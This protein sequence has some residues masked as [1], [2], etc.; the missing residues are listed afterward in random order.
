M[1][2]SIRLVLRS[3]VFVVACVALLAPLTSSAEVRSGHDVTI[4]EQEVISE[5]LYVFARSFTLHGRVNGD[6]TVFASEVRIPG[7]ITGDLLAAAGQV[8]IPG[9]VEGSARVAAGETEITGRVGGDVAA[10][11]GQ[12][13]FGASSRVDRDVLAATSAAEL[14]GSVQG[15]VVG[16]MGALTIA[17][18]VGGN[19][20]VKT[21]KLQLLDGAKIAGTLTYRSEVPAEVAPNASVQGG[22]NHLPVEAEAV[23]RGPVVA[24]LVGWLRALIGLFGLGVAFVLLFPELSRRTVGTLRQSPL[25]SLGLGVAALIGVPVAAVL[26]F[27]L[28]V[29]LGGW[30]LGLLLLAL[31]AIGLALSFPAVGLFA[32]RWIFSRA[33]RGAV[34]RLLALLVGVALLTLVGQVPLLGALVL[35]AAL[36]LGLGALLLAALRGSVDHSRAAAAGPA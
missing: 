16:G 21:D 18:P 4:G 15:D 2:T 10:G 8:S 22:L 23:Q 34:H 27:V 12:L 31:F 13:R 20:N 36:L 3:S 11:T 6:V 33:G 32:G 5:N 24:F 28:G 1:A 19:V 29:F 7:S 25:A 14:R 17:A 30:W 9:T 26:L 35:L